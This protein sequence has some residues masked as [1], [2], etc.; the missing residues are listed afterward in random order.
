MVTGSPTRGNGW[1]GWPRCAT[2]PSAANGVVAAALRHPRAAHLAGA[3]ALAHALARRQLLLVLDNCERVI[4][5]AAELCGRA[6]AR[7]RRRCGCWPPGRGRCASPRRR[8]AKLVLL[9]IDD[10]PPPRAA[11]AIALFADRAEQVD[12]FELDSQTE[13]LVGELVAE[14]DEGLWPSK[15]SRGQA[16]SLGVRPILDRDRGRVRAAGRRRQ[17][18]RAAAAA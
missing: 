17:A 7:R 10:R 16:D 11:E 3:D 15:L 18:G 5:A 9:P 1:P 4:E 8:A 6:A 2:R 12:G 14:L 13:P